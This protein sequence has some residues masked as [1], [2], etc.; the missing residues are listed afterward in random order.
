MAVFVLLG[1]GVAVFVL[2]GVGVGV[3]VGVGFFDTTFFA[4]AFFAAGFLG[5][6]FALDSRAMRKAQRLPART[7]RNPR[8]FTGLSI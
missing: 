5:L 7:A 4:G 3:G 1:V 6:V 8:L 2:L